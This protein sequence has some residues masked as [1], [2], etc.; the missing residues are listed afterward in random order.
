MV[1]LSAMKNCAQHPLR[2]WLDEHGVRHSFCARQ[3]GIHKQHLH[4]I[5]KCLRWPS[6]ELAQRFERFTNG[7]VSAACLIFYRR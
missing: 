3:V 5:L 7:E 6:P 1:Y 2:Q 4:Q